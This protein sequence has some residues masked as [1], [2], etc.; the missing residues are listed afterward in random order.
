MFY[1][2]YIFSKISSLFDKLERKEKRDPLKIIPFFTS[3]SSKCH[4]VSK[5]INIVLENKT[6]LKMKLFSTIL[7]LDWSF[8]LNEIIEDP[9]SKIPSYL[10]QY[11]RSK[12]NIE[13]NSK[14]SESWLG[15]QICHTCVLISM[16]WM[17]RCKI[18]LEIQ[19][20]PRNL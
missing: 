10:Y 13:P 7:W 19:A 2:W 17:Y 15:L 14:S 4:Q 20:R 5:K 3:V 6:G 9:S 11:L 8:K 12:C 16:Y 1:F 18:C